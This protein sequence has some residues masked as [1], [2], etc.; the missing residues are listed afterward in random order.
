MD[1]LTT[2]KPT[3]PALSSEAEEA[4][5][6][7]LALLDRLEYDF[8]PPTPATHSRHLH[9]QGHADARS[10]RDALGWSM[11]FAPGEIDA[12]VDEL[13][14]RAHMLS[15]EGHSRLRS[16]V[17]VSRLHGTLLL[18]SAYPTDDSDSVFLG[19]DS[20]RFAD[21]I[22]AEMSDVADG[23]RI[24]D[25]GAGAGAGGITAARRA[26][27]ARL[28]LADINTEALFLAGLNARHA[29]LTF[30]TVQVPAPQEVEGTFN[31]IVSHP[32]FMIDTAGRAYRDGGDLHGARLSLDWTLACIEKLAPGG[33]FVLHTGV[34]IVDG[35]DVLLAP[36]RDGIDARR[37]AWSYRE[38]DPDIFSED[39]DQPGYEEVERI[40]AVG[41]CIERTNGGET[42]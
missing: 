14:D 42:L 36:L 27:G 3:A 10:L 33:R 20:Y 25:Y 4:L 41:L 39:L 1:S 24:L 15:R 28:T 37:F 5:L 30:E 26:A 40:A 35:R 17:R 21:L 32:P 9:H 19:P 22:A 38:L 29:G 13:L 31:L 6:E 8:V 12:K 23:G 7:L 11:A 18:H 2:M 16:R 34:S